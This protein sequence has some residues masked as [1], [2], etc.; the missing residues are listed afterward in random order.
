[1]LAP[2]AK[3]R[4]GRAWVVGAFVGTHVLSVSGD[5]VR[6]SENSCHSSATFEH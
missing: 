2:T 1:M 3:I 6:H 5:K 4:L